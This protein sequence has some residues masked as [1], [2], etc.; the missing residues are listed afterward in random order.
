MNNIDLCYLNNSAETWPKAPGV[1][2]AMAKAVSEPPC[3]SGRGGSMTS[4]SAVSRCR[5]Y[6][7]E[8][9]NVPDTHNIVL[10]HNATYALNM[11]LLGLPVPVV[12]RTVT[13]VTEHN[14]V[15][16][17]LYERR[18]KGDA[19][20]KFIG[21]DENGIIDRERCAGA[22]HN[23][24]TLVVLNHIS[25]VTGLENPVAE[26]FAE[27][28]AHNVI[29]ILDASQS[30]G[31]IPVHPQEL[32]ADIVAFAGHKGLHGPTGIGCLYLSPDIDIDP[33]VFGGTG[34][35]SDRED[36]PDTLP[37]RLE[38]G[39][40]NGISITGLN[41][42]LEWCLRESVINHEREMALAS[43]LIYDLSKVGGV[44]LFTPLYSGYWSAG[45]VSFAIQ[46]WPVEEAA[47]ILESSFAIRCRSGLHCAPLIHQELGSLPGGTLRFSISS[48]NSD[49]EIDYAVDAVRTIA[50]AG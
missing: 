5:H 49:D 15:L 26:I 42:A 12:T 11:A 10:T 20:I 41:A 14:S 17:P 4:V 40:P 13:S 28:K 44:T 33:F 27:A 2:L 32:H 16:R 35:Q 6:I 48:F 22:I 18:R 29:T 46:G 45:V 1:D 34:M 25:N 31:K 43:R 30:I 8:I 9:L 38:S 19:C 21:V 36:M 7:K 24:A 39:T 37:H 3:Y 50:G 23:G 47:Q